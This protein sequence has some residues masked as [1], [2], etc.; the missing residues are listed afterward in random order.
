MPLSTV[1]R[2]ALIL[3][4]AVLAIGTAGCGSSGNKS[5]SRTSTTP[6]ASGTTAPGGPT[7]TGAAGASDN[8]AIQDFKFSPDPLNVKQGSKVTVA[9]LDDNVPHSVTADDGSFDT[10]IF[11]KS[12]GPKTITVSHGGT[13]HYHCQVHNF[14]KGTIN[15]T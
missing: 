14:M 5:P 9:I 13:I 6:G 1:S 3:A 10:G 4:V 15:A 12:T 2:S 11:M 8:I 7:S